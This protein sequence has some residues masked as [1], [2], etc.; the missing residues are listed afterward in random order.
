MDIKLISELE[1]L[2]FTEIRQKDICEGQKRKTACFRNI[3][4]EQLT[5]RLKAEFFLF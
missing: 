3:N 1:K 5:E 4:S 2:G